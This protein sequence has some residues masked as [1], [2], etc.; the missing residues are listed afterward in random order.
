MYIYI[1]ILFSLYVSNISYRC[2]SDHSKP[3]PLSKATRKHSLTDHTPSGSHSQ[4]PIHPYSAV[5]DEMGQLLSGSKPSWYLHT[6]GDRYHRLDDTTTDVHT[7]SQ[8]THHPPSH[9]IHTSHTPESSHAHTKRKSS[10]EPV[11][12]KKTHSQHRTQEDKMASIREDICRFTKN[13]A[14]SADVIPAV[15]SRWSKFLS[16]GGEEEEGGEGESVET[17]MLQSRLAVARYN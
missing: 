3:H 1:Y 8:H 15:S 5:S 2:A 13:T 4:T 12:T 9:T 11:Q 6:S 14:S 7:R 16:E 17:H 10:S